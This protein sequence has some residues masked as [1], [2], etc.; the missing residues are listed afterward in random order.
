MRDR[1][2]GL[3]FIILG[4]GLQLQFVARTRQADKERTIQQL[5]N[6]R[7]LLPKS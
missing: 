2:I 4:V 6:C 7:L 5:S 3:F 1:A